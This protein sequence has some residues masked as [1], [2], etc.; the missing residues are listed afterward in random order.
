MLEKL[1]SLDYERMYMTGTVTTKAYGKRCAMSWLTTC[2]GHMILNFVL[3]AS[4][5][6][7]RLTGPTGDQAV[8]RYRMKN[9]MNP[10]AKRSMWMEGVGPE[11]NMCLVI[12][13][14][15]QVQQ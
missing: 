15:M 13:V 7:K 11:V 2:M 6:S 10:R 1:L 4:R 12:Q 5:L 8:M 9:S 14:L 3:S